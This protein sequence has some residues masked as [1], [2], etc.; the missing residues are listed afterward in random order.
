MAPARARSLPRPRKRFG[1]HFLRDP[2]V[3]ARI[4]AA[5][6]PHA[7]KHI[8]EIGPGRGVLTRPLLEA[9][10]QLDVVEIDR[11]LAAALPANVGIDSRG[12]RVHCVDAL[13]FRLDSVT[14]AAAPVWVVGNL[15]YNIS[16]PLIFHLLEQ[17]PLIAGMVFML[18]KEVAERL[19]AG[20]GSRQYGR[21]SVIVQYHCAVER[22]FT[23]GPGAFTPPP[24]VDSSVV[25]LTPLNRSAD[26]RA[27]SVAT[28]VQLVAQ[29]FSRRRK[30]LRNALKEYF[31]A[32]QLAEVGV[33]PNARAET[34]AVADYIRLA[35]R[36]ATVSREVM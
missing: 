30:T 15:P 26:D 21:L 33:D 34:L 24:K 9:A 27:V 2:A 16:S 6:A 23:V 22:L 31:S 7:G 20:P 8:V 10:G 14:T 36:K 11:D 12:L 28:L 35:N 13:Q 1:Q 5:I 17:L 3:V 18:Q 25:R 32:A 4:V 29:A 19:A